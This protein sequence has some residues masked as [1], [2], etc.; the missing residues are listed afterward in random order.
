MV[1]KKPTP[2][3][4]TH[5]PKSILVPPSGARETSEPFPVV[6]IGASAG[7][8]ESF[9]QL[10]AHLHADTGLA[11]VLV[12]HLDPKHPSILGEL[13]A[14]ETPLPVHEIKN[15]MPIKPNQVYVIP[16]NH[17]LSIR[18]GTLQL[19]PRSTLR[20]LHTP[21]DS[22]FR[23]LAE[24]CGNLAIGVVLSGT[25][26]DGTLG[27]RAIKAE[28]GFTFAQDTQSAKYDGMPHSAI[29]AG[30][31]DF[32][33][34]P[35]KIAQELTRLHNHPYVQLA[36]T[37]EESPLVGEDDL[38]KI[39]LLL[40]AATGVE[41]AYYKPTTI[42]RRIARRMLLLR[43]DK[44][45]GYARY[46]K[47]NPDEVNA[48]YQDLLINVTSFLRD[49]DLFETLKK[50]VF[51]RLFKDRRGD[52]PIRFWVPA[53]STGEEAYSLAMCLF[54]YLG[55]NL[56][57]T[58]I[59]IFATDVNETAIE[60]ARAGIYPES[61]ANDVTS[62]R[63][64]RFF[65]KTSGGYQ[66]SKN[67]RDVCVFA[68]QDL[69]KDPPF[70][71]IDLISCRNL[72]IYL[73]PTM[74]KKIIPTFH[75]ALNPDGV[76][77]LGNSET[78]GAHADLFALS[79]KKQK[80]YTKKSNGR[81]VN[82]DFALSARTVEKARHAPL[83]LA[84]DFDASKEADHLLLARYA[85]ASVLVNDALEVLQFRGHTGDYLEPASGAA[86]F[87][88]LKMARE[89]LGPEL[90]SALT[91][92]RKTNSPVRRERLRVKSRRINLEVIPITPSAN[93]PKHH[94]LVLF[95]DTAQARVPAS[96][97]KINLTKSAAEREIEHL[98]QELTTTN[99]YLQ[100]I[101]AQ[102]ETTNEELR[103]AL[104]EIQSSNEELQSTNEEMETA[105]EELQSTN[106]ELTTVNE[107]MQNRNLELGQLNNDLVN[108]LNSVQIP[109][110]ILG[111]DL[112]IRRFTPVTEK[113]LN[114]IPTDVG[115]P[116]SDLRPNVIVPDLENLVRQVMDSLETHELEMAD[117]QGH[118]YSMRI[119]PY[120]TVENKIDGVLI[121]WL[122]VTELKTNAFQIQAAREY[123]EAI[124][125]TVREPLLVLDGELRVQTANRA[126]YQTFATS[127][128]ETEDK[129]IYALDDGAWNQPQ[130][131]ELLEQILPSNTQF[132]N[133]Q[134]EAEFPGVGLRRFLLSAR[135]VH[136]TADH[137]PLIL[138]AMQ[139]QA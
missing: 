117:Q 116:L 35:E 22:F 60:K 118:W 96:P 93:A 114:V 121:A 137:T 38:R 34:P 62:V 94:F 135:R 52:T 26:T 9:T 44:L 80:I 105:K 30:V 20:G 85:P 10:L 41:F 59:Q 82:F 112:H 124:V 128:A 63:L 125:A 54:E 126:F 91:E 19:T 108:L 1:N 51:P 58:P 74:Q 21:I 86:N 33:L 81:H 8:L 132:E 11:F 68:R 92:A 133:F 119:R 16:P 123:A 130:L 131:R 103:S 49:P 29:A 47:E 13:L 90:R 99:E 100:A 134:L 15:G 64:R 43:I 136:Q 87:N 102:R 3:R 57:H 39:F 17:D 32:I 71:R 67:I 12:Q 72:L 53:C 109:I 50:K 23:S 31:V 120:R 36:R 61:I 88:L 83:E 104:E 78:I 138:L 27:L 127:A 37:V 2:K 76:L 106:E 79:D 115:R 69:T 73:V 84:S 24:E 122:D 129:P 110:I 45:A 14:R 113:L 18:H 6:G 111:S 95:E 89:G 77:V 4:I 40:R 97:P 46:L 42:K 28:G 66:I 7:G 98:R 101:I 5:T 25:G 56:D 75:Y 107:E 65:V 48:L 55:N 70:S 139:E